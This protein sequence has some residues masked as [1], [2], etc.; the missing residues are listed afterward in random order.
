MASVELADLTWQ[1][2]E[3]VLEPDAIILIP[4][5][6]AAKEHG[7]HPQL[8]NDRVLAECLKDRV[9]RL[10]SVVVAPT[11][12]YLHYPAFSDYPGSTSL[13]FDTACDLLVDVVRSLAA[14]GPRRFYVLNTGLSTVGPSRVAGDIL[15]ASGILLRYTDMSTVGLVAAGYRPSRAGRHQ[16]LGT[17]QARR[18]AGA[19][20]APG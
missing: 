5:G 2:A 20:A 6:A 4:L 16:V 1:Q 17:V 10:T 8:D 19:G 9:S 7:P 14:H 3:T 13:G 11:L 12:S 18:L 15:G